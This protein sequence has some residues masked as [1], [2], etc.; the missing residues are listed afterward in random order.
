[1]AY[2][3]DKKGRKLRPG[4]S[5]RTNGKYQFKYIE[6]GKPKFV[7]SWR[8]EPHDKLP[9][10][11]RPCIALRDLEKEIMHD[12]EAGLKVSQQSITVMELVEKYIKTKRNVRASTK[13]GYKTVCNILKKEEFSLKRI[14][15]V[16]VS[17]AKIFLIKLQE[18]DGRS[19]S[20][21]H[22]IRGVLRPA[23]Q[24]A[25]DDDILMKN[26]FD[27]EL[28]NVIVN[29]SVR[30][31]AIT[32]KQMRQFLKFVKETRPYYK[33]YEGFYILFQTG[34]RISEFC[35]LTLSDIDFENNTISIVKQLHRHSDM[36]YHIEKTKTEAGKRIIP[37]TPDVRICFEA[38]IENRPN[39][40]NEMMVDGVIGFLYLDD[41]GRPYVAMHWQHKFNHAV[42]RYNQIYKEQ[43]P[44]ITPHVCRHTYCSNMAKSGMNPKTLQ[45]LMGHSDISVTMNTYTHLGLDDSVLEINRLQEQERVLGEFKEEEKGTLLKMAE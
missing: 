45:Y 34:M 17:D 39:L 2:R 27:F 11:K 19:Y 36:T 3:K 5:I 1:M 4:E 25:V 26:P 16:R 9:E 6:N 33:F 22:T 37:M 35:G 15:E 12:L 18:E 42:N 41:K 10:G 13:T 23:F 30:R 21:I 29:D 38:I 20:S 28:C 43:L 7:Y 14:N 24:L 8:L 44:N 31:E 32:R 40:K